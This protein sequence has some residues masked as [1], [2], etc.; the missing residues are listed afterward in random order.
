[1][2]MR[3]LIVEDEALVAMMV[4]DAVESAGHDIA[5]VVSNITDAVAAVVR[6]DFDVALLDMNLHGQKAH[7]LP[8]T[9]KARG[10]PFAFV[11]G[12][13]QSGILDKFA[14]APVVTKPFRFED[15]AKAL[16]SLSAALV[17]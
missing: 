17:R 2:R 15:I 12:Y 10:T 4:E 6:G 14:D 3:V 1:M 16:T 13:S 9:L 11:T 5:A 8:V 7:A